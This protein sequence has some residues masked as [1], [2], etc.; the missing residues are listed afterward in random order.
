MFGYNL[1]ELI[2]NVYKMQFIAKLLKK[3]LLQHDKIA[4]L[5]NT[6]MFITRSNVW[7]VRV[8]VQKIVF[9]SQNDCKKKNYR[10]KM[11]FHLYLQF[12]IPIKYKIDSAKSKRIKLLLFILRIKL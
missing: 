3:H 7:S 4:V 5:R 1:D 9:V 11:T 8:C 10:K 2:T 6:I 12:C